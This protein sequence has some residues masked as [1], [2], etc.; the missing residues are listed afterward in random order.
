MK[1]IV[2]T[3]FLEMVETQMGPQMAQDIIDDARLPNEGAYTAVGY[4]PTGELVAMIQSLATRTGKSMPK[5]IEHFG[6]YFF[7]SLV[8]AYPIFFNEDPRF[9]AV[10]GRR[11]F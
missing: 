6:G 8:R 3:E 10:W 7:S 2:F 11:P 9:H 1:G 4:Y 5:L